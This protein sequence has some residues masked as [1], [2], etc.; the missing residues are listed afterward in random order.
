MDKDYINEL[1]TRMRSNFT[2]DDELREEVIRVIT[3][4]R[5][6]MEDVHISAKQNGDRSAEHISGLALGKPEYQVGDVRI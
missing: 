6:F 3:R 5:F 4:Q 2:G 1:I